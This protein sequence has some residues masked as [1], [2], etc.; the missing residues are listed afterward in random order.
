[1][2]SERCIALGNND[3]SFKASSCYVPFLSINREHVSVNGLWIVLFDILLNMVTRRGKRALIEAGC[4]PRRSFL[5][6]HRHIYR[7]TGSGKFQFLTDACSFRWEKNETKNVKWEISHCSNS[8][9]NVISFDRSFILFAHS[10]WT[11]CS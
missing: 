5:L 9:S 2:A 11:V 1:M 10:N 7:H 4:R 3:N 6:I 8:C